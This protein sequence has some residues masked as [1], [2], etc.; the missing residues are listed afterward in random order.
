MEL[1]LT[2][3]RKKSQFVL[4]E[5]KCHYEQ[6][7]SQNLT[8]TCIMRTILAN[9]KD[10]ADLDGKIFQTEGHN[11]AT[12]YWPQGRCGKRPHFAHDWSTTYKE[13]HLV[14]W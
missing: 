6:V 11:K 13:I 8:C 14:I 4:G 5:K 10:I 9:E 12:K 7:I 1:S 2:V 3:D